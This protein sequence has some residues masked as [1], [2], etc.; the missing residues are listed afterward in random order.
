MQLVQTIRGKAP[1]LYMIHVDEGERS[2]S[3][4]CGQSAARDLANDRAALDLAFASADAL[5][6]SGITL[7]I[8]PPQGRETLLA[9]LIEPF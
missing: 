3:Y 2:F 4:W 6:F 7:A 5:Y 9:G 1:G 8:L